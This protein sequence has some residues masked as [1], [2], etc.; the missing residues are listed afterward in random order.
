[1]TKERIR[2]VILRNGLDS[3]IYAELADANEEFVQ[4]IKTSKSLDELSRIW[5]EMQ[6]R[7]F[8]SHRATSNIQASISENLHSL[9]KN[10]FATFLLEIL[11]HNM[12]YVPFTEIDDEQYGLDPETRRLNKKMFG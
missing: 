1:V 9:D 10:E 8:L 4:K 2:Q 3:F 11:D 6:E 5:T 7:A 12:L